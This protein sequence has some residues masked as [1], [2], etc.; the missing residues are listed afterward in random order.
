MNTFSF[1]VCVF[2]DDL[3]LENVP[4]EVI[5]FFCSSFAWASDWDNAIA[6]WSSSSSFSSSSDLPLLDAGVCG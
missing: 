3:G 5:L 6:N 4:L 2:D 1:N